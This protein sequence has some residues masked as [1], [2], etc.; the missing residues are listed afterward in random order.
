MRKKNYYT[1]TPT[2]IYTYYLVPTY[3][4][5]CQLFSTFFVVKYNPVS[6]SIYI[7]IFVSTFIIL[8]QNLCYMLCVV[9]QFSSCPST[10]LSVTVCIYYLFI[11]CSKVITFFLGFSAE[12]IQ[13]ILKLS[14]GFQRNKTKSIAL[15]C[16]YHFIKH[17]SKIVSFSTYYTY[18]N[19]DG[20][21][22]FF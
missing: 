10:Q 20:T 22:F 11:I 13:E 9:R 5:K 14:S 15:S 7:S 1:Y 6:Q 19:F 3:F 16:S 17:D 18:M 21:I 4:A 12:I 2:L 8:R